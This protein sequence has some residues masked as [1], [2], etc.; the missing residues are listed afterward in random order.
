MGGRDIAGAGRVRHALLVV[1]L[2]AAALAGATEAASPPPLRLYEQCVSAAERRGIVRFTAVDGTR[3]IGVAFGKGSRGIVL[4][5]QGTQG[6]LCSWVPYARVLARAGYHVLA[7][8]HRGRGSSGS[9]RSVAN[10]HRVD[11]DVVAAAKALRRRGA[12]RI[13]LGG[14]SLGGT[15]VLAAA[16]RITPAVA[17]VVTFGAPQTYVRVDAVAAVR[18]VTVPLLLVAAEDDSPFDDDARALYAA[19]ASDDKRL[20]IFPGA[21]HGAPQLRTPAIR[22]LVDEWIAARF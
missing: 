5:P 6:D 2:A 15:A 21:V 8:D 16:P 13:V 20:E 18:R 9:A 17:G 4:A 10:L 11:L 14:A 7:I 1:A 19:A 22:K 12:T 3:L